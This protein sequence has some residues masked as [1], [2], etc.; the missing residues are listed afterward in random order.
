ML[1]RFNNTFS[2][3]YFPMMAF[4]FPVAFKYG[5]RLLDSF[6]ST[7]FTSLLASLI[8]SLLK[9]LLRDPSGS[10]S[11]SSG[12]FFLGYKY[13]SNTMCSSRLRE[14]IVGKHS[15]LPSQPQKF[16]PSKDLPCTV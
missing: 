4:C 12:G 14:M 5:E 7:N 16:S 10:G 2:A 11:N 15:R 3:A 13:F 8:A 6:D 9:C 1:D